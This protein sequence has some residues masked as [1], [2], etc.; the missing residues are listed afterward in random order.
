M[1]IISAL[2]SLGFTAFLVVAIVHGIRKTGA[3]QRY[4]KW[5]GGALLLSLVTA[6]LGPDVPDVSDPSG[7]RPAHTSGRAGE[8]SSAQPSSDLD[9]G[10]SSTAAAREDIYYGLGEA[11][12]VGGFQVTVTKVSRATS[13]G[14][15][16]VSEN[17]S[18]VFLLVVVAVK[19]E[20]TESRT[21]SSDSF[22][23]VDGAGREF[24]VSTEASTTLEFSG[25]SGGFFLQSINP[26]LSKSTTLPFDVPEDAL[27]SALTLHVRAGKIWS[28]ETVKIALNY[29]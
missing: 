19:N 3:A 23:L 12:P 20:D 1:A 27:N 28:Q 25:R 9:S 5:A 22:T 29:D 6:A 7:E 8:G 26:G 16:F 18:G 10:S 21:I 15:E 24:D 11:V 17:A 2:S 14:N 13:V 4:L